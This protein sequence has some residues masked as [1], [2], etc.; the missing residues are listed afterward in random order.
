MYIHSQGQQFKHTS[1]IHLNTKY[2]SLRKEKKEKYI[3]IICIDGQ[4]VCLIN[5]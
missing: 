2:F 5:L 4:K 1:N 3:T